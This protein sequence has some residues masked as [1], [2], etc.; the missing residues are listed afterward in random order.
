M[1]CSYPVRRLEALWDST[2]LIW[3]LKQNKKK[4][5]QVDALSRWGEGCRTGASISITP[6]GCRAAAAEL[7]PW[8]RSPQQGSG[9]PQCCDLKG[10]DACRPAACVTRM[11]NN[12]Y[13]CSPRDFAHDCLLAHGL[14][15]QALAVNILYQ[16][17]MKGTIGG[18]G[19]K[20]VGEGF[21]CWQCDLFRGRCM[22]LRAVTEIGGGGR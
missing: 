11:V 8:R 1:L 19:W 9:R 21:Q 22:R 15:D 7:G 6:N 10:F 14:Q 20:S 3:P 18:G 13:L 5:Q 2:G 12:Q 16:E 4:T 17:V